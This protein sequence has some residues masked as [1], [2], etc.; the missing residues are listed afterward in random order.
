MGIST[1]EAR[2]RLYEIIREDV[3]FEQKAK[4]ALELG[5]QYLGVDNGHLTRIDQ[6]TGH[7]QAIVSTDSEDG[8][9]PPGLELDL[10][11][12]YCRRTLT[13]DT[14]IV[15]N[16]APNQGWEDDVAFETH[17]L[18]CY[19]G[20][21]II[22]DDEPYGTVCFVSEDPNDEEF[23]DGETMFAELIT[24]LLERELENEQHEAELNRQTNLALVLNRVLR[25]NL[26]N[27]M[28]IIRGYTQ[29]MADRIDED[30]ISEIALDHVD[31]LIDLSEK[32]RE[33]D[34]VVGTESER[35][36]MDL[37]SLIKNV[38]SGIEH[39][40]PSASISIEAGEPVSATLF[41]SIERAITELIE[42]AA[43]HSGDDPRVS[44]TIKTAPNTVEIRI[45]DNGLGL[46]AHEADV[47]KTGTETPLTHGTGLGLWL[48]H[49]IISSHGGS[50]GVTDTGAGTTMEI[51]IPRIQSTNVMEQLNILE[52]ARDLYQA[53]FEEATDG[54]LIVNTDAQIIDTN[55]EAS[56]TL[57]IERRRLLGRS[58]PELLPD[59]FDFENTWESIQ[60][61]EH[62][63]ETVVFDRPDGEKRHINYSVATD[64]VPG[65][66]LI[67]GRDISEQISSK[68]EVDTVIENL[69]GYVYRHKFA[70]GWPLEFVKG[71][72]KDVTG[73]TTAEL[74]EEIGL[75][76]KII[77]PDDQEMVATAVEEGLTDTG[78]FDLTYRI[79][80]KDGDKRW[81][82]DQGQ[83]VEDP[84][85]DEEYLDG[86]IMD[87]TQQK[88]RE[89]TL[90]VMSRRLEAILENTT[91]PMFMKDNNGKH[92]FVNRAYRELFGLQDEEIVGRTDKELH[93]PEM[94]E[95]V[96][97]NDRTVIERVEPVE[98][99]EHIN[100]NS[101]ERVFLSAKVPIYDTGDRS[102]P[103]TP[104]A[105][106]GVATDITKRKEYEDR[107]Y[108]EQQFVRSIFRSLPDPFYVFDTN[109]YLIRW[110]EELES[111]IGYTS[112][113]LDGM[114]VT[115]LIPED[116]ATRVEAKFRQVLEE[117]RQVTIESAI[118]TK[119]GNRISYEF[120][121]GP[122]E[123]SN[124]TVDGV[125]GIARDIS[126]REE[127]EEELVRQNNRLE[128]F[129]SVVSH[130]LRNPLNIAATRLELAQEECDSE[131]LD[132]ARHAHERMDALIDD[133][134]TVA[135]EGETVT[136][137]EEIHLST[138][139]NN[140]WQT[141]ATGNASLIVE[142]DQTIRG[143][144]TRLKQVFENLFRNA[145]EHGGDEVTIRVGS[146]ANGFYIEDD[147]NE[148]PKDEHE[149]V[150]DAG[151]STSAEGTGFG[152]NIVRQIVEAHGWEIRA[153]DGSDVGARFEITGVEFIGK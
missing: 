43:K 79:I 55:T 40:Y 77:H 51:S 57:G 84:L 149:A 119:D 33:L 56:T 111:V 29:I 76:E 129:A 86:F 41:P 83:L 11:T 4:E 109:G 98:R 49:W 10:G 116:E 82:R 28:A 115:E 18:H 72:A 81:I 52:R 132:K 31:R 47:L 60:R 61:R 128:D 26:R 133:I 97:A 88:E 59:D 22:L 45:A 123:D 92:I 134:L 108:E 75:A 6:Q 113:E 34:R 101:E 8:T 90:R 16:D 24:Q 121:G 125:T 89:Q 103:E 110:N 126:E 74:E 78:H 42:N 12:T 124:G 87:V 150:F 122:I 67:I 85:T 71:S 62:F 142:T 3:P 131:H 143:N 50:L 141:V 107:L 139:A 91:T 5:K 68:L 25:H 146:G 15:L 64:I 152:L 144:R 151:Y 35:K 44:I 46:A 100:V 30:R 93:P 136:E 58:L 48:S 147:G 73:Y 36:P 20:T 70:E 17:G 13:E 140:C 130:D 145:V 148:I 102:D 23:S 99:E 9:Y 19:I 69:P 114:Y 95:E 21:T 127:R 118:E 153:T 105:V 1:E 14:Q 120:T 65:Q 117:R 112:D 80:T 39:R 53:A 27:D 54:M 66:H 138:L 104:V 37:V 94:A 7:W 106:F 135:R 63:Q 32:A 137:R 2:Q 96:W 38:T